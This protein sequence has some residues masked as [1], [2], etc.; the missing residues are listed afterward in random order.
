MKS[1][2]IKDIALKANVS[3]TTVSFII[4]GKAK[5]KAISDAVI[6]RV[7][8]IIVDSGYE[9]NQIARSLRTGN[10]NIIALIV[11]DISNSFFSKIARLI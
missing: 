7:Q 2:S 10:S 5:E 11:E 4:N 8:K 3:I 1:L 9:P 6:K